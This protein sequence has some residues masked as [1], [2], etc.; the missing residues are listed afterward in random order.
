M[1]EVLVLSSSYQPISKTSIEKAICLIYLGKAYSIK[2]S[3]KVLRSVT[4]EI[5]IPLILVMPDAKYVKRRDIAFSK[6][7]IFKRDGYA[8]VYC[9]ESSKEQLTLDHVIPRNR[10]EEI[11]KARGVDFAL[12]S[13][14]NCV[15]ACRTCNQRK[16]N[17]LLSE[18]GWEE[19]HPKKPLALLEIDWD[20]L[21]D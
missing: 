6:R 8:C 19:I 5:K 16:S 7:S 17:H 15:T 20:T 9:G 1:K 14:E 11:K 4:T 10:W 2:D 21:L 3:D 18:L 13:F 12:N